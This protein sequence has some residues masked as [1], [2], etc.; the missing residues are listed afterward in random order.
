S[1][2][3]EQSI[4]GA[5]TGTRARSS[6]AVALVAFLATRAGSPQPRQRIAGLFWPESTDAQALTNLRRELHQLR[7]VL[8]DE[9]SLVVTPVDLCWRDTE[10]CRV[11]L[12]VF[13]A[14]R[15]AALAAAAVGDDEGVLAHAA[16]AIAEYPGGPLPGGDQDWL[17]DARPEI[18]RQ[19]VGLC[20]LLGE[21]RARAGDLAGAVD[22]ARRRIQLEPLEEV[23]YRTLM[24]LQ[25]ELGDRAGA[26]STYHHC[27]SLL[28]REL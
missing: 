27:A 7:Q 21:T 14:E 15:E 17:L 23:G 4:T 25:A 5:G 26:V 9:S 20:D 6:R 16:G 3:G 11:D 13:S 19:C 8:G 1:L 12:R 10:T 22:V 28:E 18:E 2:L 24:Q